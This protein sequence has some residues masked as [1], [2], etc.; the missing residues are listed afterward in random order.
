MKQF[1]EKLLSLGLVVT[2]KDGDLSLKRAKLDNGRSPYDLKKDTEGIVPYLKKHKPELVAYLKKSKN[3]SSSKKASVY[4]LT[5]LQEGMLFHALLEE[6]STAYVVQ[7]AVEFPSGIDTDHFK[8]SWSYVIRNHSILRTAFFH[9][10]LSIPVQRVFPEILPPIQQ[11]DFSELSN[12]EIRIKIDNFLQEDKQTPFV[13]EKAPLFRITLIKTGDESYT[14]VFTNHHIVM[15]GWS[16]SVLIEEFL[17]A[18]EAYSEG[19][20]PLFKEEDKFEDYIRYLAKQDPD[21]EENFWKNYIKGLE[22]PTLLPFIDGITSRNTDPGDLGELI[23]EIDEDQTEKIKSFAQKNR[24]TPNTLIQGTWALLLQHYSGNSNVVYGVTVSGRPTDLENSEKRVGMYINTLPLHA[25]IR[26]GEIITEW[27]KSIQD[28]QIASREHQYT[29]L[30]SIQSMTGIKGELFDTIMAFENYPVA[31]M[32]KQRTMKLEVS[33]VKNQE[34]TNYPLAISIGLHDKM[35]LKFGFNKNLLAAKTVEN[36]RDHFKN[37]LCQLISGKELQIRDIEVIT[38]VEREMFEGWN[39]TFTDYSGK[40]TLLSLFSEKVNEYPTKTALVDQGKEY[41]FEDLDKMSTDLAGYLHKSAQ[42]TSESIVAVELDRGQWFVI[43]ILA[44]LKCNAAY[45]PIDPQYPKERIDFMKKDSQCKFVINKNLISLFSESDHDYHSAP[46]EN[47]APEALAYIIYTSGSTGKPKGVM[48]EHRNIVNTILS[49][50]ENTN[51]SQSDRCLQFS[52]QSFDASVWEI[53]ISLLSGATL[54]IIPDDKKKDTKLFSDFLNDHAITWATLPPAFVRLLQMEDIRPLKTLITAG[55]EAPEDKVRTLGAHTNYVNAYGPTETSICATTFSGDL[56]KKPIPIG[57]PIANTRV[58]IVDRFLR[59]TPVGIP[60][61]LCISGRGVARGYLNRE[62]LTKERFVTNPYEENSIM[63]RTGDLVKRLPDGNIVFIGRVDNQVKIRGYRIEPGEIEQRLLAQHS[64]ENACVIAYDDGAND[65]QLVAYVVIKENQAF[66]KEALQGS[67]NEQLPDYM[68][69]KLWIELDELPIN[70]SGKIDRKAL[71]NPNYEAAKVA[72]VAP[73]TETEKI[74]AS[75]WEELLKVKDIGRYDN[76]FEL[77]GHSLL[78]TRLVSAIRKQLEIELPIK[79][80]F[81]YPTVSLMAAQLVG[82]SNRMTLPVVKPVDNHKGK[83]PLSFSQ[84]RLWFLDN[85]NGSV[86]YHLPFVLKIEGTPDTDL[87]AKSLATIIDRHEILR[88]VYGEQDGIGY[89]EVISSSDWSLTREEVATEAA[90]ESSLE[91]F[92]NHPFDLGEDYMFRACLYRVAGVSGRYVL[93]GVFHHIASDGWSN[94]ILVSEFTELYRSLADGESA[95]LPALPIQYGDYALWQRSY[96]EGEVLEQQLQ[97]WEDQ[98]G[99]TSVLSLPTDYPR[100]SVQSTRGA[101]LRFSL[102][103]SL[104][105]SLEALS[106][107]EGTTLFMTLLAGFKVLLYRYT[108]QDDICVGTP[109]ANRTQK[110]LEGLIGFFV[111]TLALRSDLGGNPSFKELLHQVKQTTLDSYDHQLA[112]FE[113]VVDRVVTSRDMSVTPVFQIMFGWQNTPETPKLEV[114][115]IQLTPMDAGAVS[116]KFDMTITAAQVKK[117]IIIDWEY[118]TDLYS[119]QTVTRMKDHFEQLLEAFVANAEQPIGDVSLVSEKARQQLLKDFNATGVAYPSSAGLMEL[120]SAQVSASGTKT[121]LVYGT[122]EMSYEALDISSGRVASY[123][124]AKGITPGSRVG[125]LSPRSMEMIISMLGILKAGGVYVPLDPSLPQDRLSFIASDA[126]LELIIGTDSDLTG[127]YAFEE[128]PVFDYK[129]TL[130]YEPLGHAVLVSPDAGAYVMYTSGTTGKP[131]GILITH[132][133]I[134][135]L[136]FGSAALQVYPEDRV[137]QWSNYAFDGSTYEIYGSLLHGASLYLIDSDTASDV[138]ALGNVFKTHRLTISFLTPALFNAFVETGLDSLSSVRKL[139]MGGEKA[140]VAHV[141]KALEILGP[142]SLMNGYGPTETTTFAITYT[143][144]DS[145]SIANGVPIGKPLA[146]TSVYIVDTQDQL[147]PVGVIGE[148]CIGGTG[149][150]QGYLNRAELNSEKFVKDPFSADP[151]ARMYRTGDLARWLPDGNIAFVGRADSQVKIRGYRIELGEIETLLLQQASVQ[152]CCVTAWEDAQG[153]KRL[154]GYVVSEQEID[155]SALQDSLGTHLPDYMVPRLWVGLDALPLTRNGKIDYGALPAPETDSL[156][157]ELYVAPESEAEQALATI[158]QELLGVAKVGVH[159]NFFDLGGDSIITIQ[160]VSRLKRYGYHLKPKDIFENQTI[161]KLSAVVSNNTTGIQGEQGLLTGESSLLPIQQW[162]FE[163]LHNGG[164]FNQSVLLSIDKSVDKSSLSAVVSKVYE[165]HDALRFRYRKEGEDWFQYYSDQIGCLDQVVIKEETTEAVSEMITDYCQQYQNSLSIGSG[166]VFRVLHITTP[167]TMDQDRLFMVAHHLVI[168]GVSWRI[169]LDDLTSHLKEGTTAE[170]VIAKGTSYREWSESLGLYAQSRRAISQL[171]YWQEVASSYA[172]LPVDHL[173]EGST[174]RLQTESYSVRLDKEHTGLLLQ[175]V[176]QV[177]GTEIE[178]LLLGCLV[179]TLT[180]W[181]NQQGVTIGLEGHGREEIGGKV[182][183]ST[184]VGWFTNLYPVHLELSDREDLGYVIKTVKEQLRR[185]PDSGMGY[186]ALRYLHPSDEV[187]SSL[188]NTRWD[189]VFNYLGQFD[190]VLEDKNVL[191]GAQEAYGD[192]VS[193]NSPFLNRFEVTASIGGG[194]LGVSFNYAKNQYDKETVESLAE[195]YLWNLRALILHCTQKEEPEKTPSDFGLHQETTVTEFESFQN[196]LLSKYGKRPESIYKLSPLQEG[197]LFHGLYDQNAG[198]YLVQLSL[199]FPSGVALSILRQSWNRIAANHSILRSAFFH[200]ELGAPVQCVFENVEVPIKEVDFS[201]LTPET[202]E[203]SWN[204]LLSKDQRTDFDF[205]QAPLFRITFVKMPDEQARMIFT[206]HHLLI[207]GWSLGVLIEEFLRTYALIFKGQQMPSI[208]HDNFK[209]YIDFIYAKNSFEELQFWENYLESFEE[210]SLLP[211]INNKTSR[212]RI[213][214]EGVDYKF[215]LD[216]DTTERIK[217]FAQKNRLTV[218]TIIQGSWAFLLRSYTGLNGVTFGVTVSGRPAELENS[219]RRV[220]MYI[221]TLPLYVNFEDESSILQWLKKLQSG[222]TAAREHQYSSLSVIQKTVGIKGDFFDTMIAFENFPVADAISENEDGLNVKPISTKEKTNYPLSI[223]VTSGEEIAMKFT[224]NEAILDEETL[225]LITS[226]FEL[227]VNQIVDITVTKLDELNLVSPEAR[228]QLLKDFNATGVA[229]P[230]S[231]GLMELFSAQVSASG[232]KTALVYGTAEMSYEALD[233]S[234]GR[235]ASYLLAKGITPGSRVGILSPRSMEMI[236]SMLG[237]LKAGGVY[238]PLDPSLPQDRLSF[239]ASDA[240]LELIIGTD[241]DLTGAYAFEE[242]PVFDYK[243]TLSYEPLGHAVTVSPDAGAYV[244]YTSGTTG[245]P[246]GALITHRNVI[247]LVFGSAPLQV[248]PEDRVLQWSNYAFDGSTYEIYGSLLHGASLYLIDSDTASDVIAL[249]N[250]FKTHRLT[251]SF[252]TPALFN[253]FVETGLESLSSVRKLIMGGEKASVAHVSKALEILGPGRL[254]N[255]YGPTETT[256]FAIT[257]TIDDSDSIASGVPIGKPLA[258]T[259]VYIVDTQD[260]LVPVGVIGELCIGGTGV[261][262]GYLNRAEL[263]SEKFVKD[264][265]RADPDA[266]MYRTGDLARWLP[267]GN[268]AF[269]GRADSQVKIRGYRI[270]LGE[271][272]TLLLQQASV[273]RCCVTAWEDAQGTKRLVGYVVSEQEIDKAALQDSLGTH[274]PDYMVPRLWV[275]LDALPLTRNGKIDYG[276]LPAPE[277]DGLSGEAYVAPESEAEQALATIWQ[278]LLGVAKVGVHDNFFDLGGHSLLAT[279]L[280]SAIR[281]QFE[282]EV[283]IKDIFI[284]PTVAQQAEMLEKAAQKISLPPI[285]TFDNTEKV[286]LSFSQERIWFL[287]QLQGSIEYHIPMIFELKGKVNAVVMENALRNIIHRHQI[288]RTVLISEE[289]TLY[290]KVL[291][292]SRWY[293]EKAILE[294]EE[295]VEETLMS[296]AYEPFDLSKDFMLRACLY[297]KAKNEY[298]LAVVFHH[299]ASDGWSNGI[300]IREFTEFYRSLISRKKPNLQELEIQYADF[301]QWQR[302]YLEGEVL[303]RMLTYWE[304]K[305]KNTTSL[306]LPTDFPRPAIQSTEGTNLYFKLDKKLSQDLVSLSQEEGVTLFMTLLAAF[307]VLLFKYTAQQDICVGSPIANRTQRELEGLIG[308]FVN[309]LALRS[310]IDSG[311]T[312][313][314]FLKRVKDTTL[315]AYDHQLVPFEKIVEKVVRTRDL[316][317]TPLFQTMFILQNNQRS[318]AVEFDGF[319]MELYEQHAQTAKYDL[320]FNTSETQDGIALEIEYSTALFKEET[321]RTMKVHFENLLS[322]IVKDRTQKISRLTLL[323]QEAERAILQKLYAEKQ[324]EIPEKTVLQRFEEQVEKNPEAI[325]LEYESE[326]FTYRQINNYAN[327]LAITLLEKHDTPYN[328]VGI[329]M[330]RSPEMIVAILAAFKAGIAYVPIDPEY[331]HERIKYIIEDAGLKSVF[332]NSSV[333]YVFENILID[334]IEEVV[335]GEMENE[336]FELPPSVKNPQ[337]QQAYV[338]Y[339]SGSTGKPKGVLVGQDT[340][341]VK[342]EEET[343]LLQIDSNL[344]GCL[345]TNFVFDVSLLDIF[346]PLTNGGKIIIPIQEEVQEVHQLKARLISG[347]VNLLQGT[348]SFFSNLLSVIEPG[349]ADS[350]SLRCCCV[351]G[352][353]LQESLVKEFQYK[354]PAVQINNHY[355]P[356]EITIDAVVLQNITSFT[357]NNIGFPLPG[358]VAYILDEA[359]QLVPKGIIGELCI[360]GNSLAKGYLNREELTDKRFIPD[361]FRNDQKSRIYRTGDL[362]R[363]LPDGSIEFIGRKDDQVKIRGYRIE[364]GEIEKN[365]TDLNQVSE[366]CVKVLTDNAGSQQLVGYVAMPESSYDKE[367][368]VSS[369]KLVLPDYMIPKIW[370]RLDKMPITINGK[371]DRKQLPEPDAQSISSVL[372]EPPVTAL[373]IKLANIWGSLLKQEKIGIHDNFFELGGHSLL[374]T[375]LV[376]AIRSQLNVEITIKDIFLKPTISGLCEQIVGLKSGRSL[377]AIKPTELKEKFPLSFSQERLW[378]IHE[379]Q[380]SVHY[381]MPLVLRIKGTVK[382]EILEGSFLEILRRHEVL[383]TRILNSEGIGYQK[384]VSAEDWKLETGTYQD[385]KLLH[386]SIYDFVKKPFNLSTDFMLRAALL[387]KGAEEHAMIVVTHHIAS[388][389]WSES[390]LMHEFTTIYKSFLEDHKLQL[391][392]VNLQYKDYAV[393]ERIHLEGATLH[394]LIKYWQNQLNGVSPLELPLDFERPQVQN[395]EGEILE[396]TIDKPLTS[397]IKTLATSN[398]STMFMTLLTAYKVFLHRYS[399]QEDIC[400]GTPVS[401]RTQAELEGVIGFFANTLALRSQITGSSTFH[402]LLEIIKNN[403]TE[404]FDHQMAPFEK[405]VDSIINE[406]DMSR[407][408]LFQTMFVFQNTPNAETVSFSGFNAEKMMFETKTSNFDLTFTITESEGKLIGAVQYATALFKRNTI[409]KMQLHFV[410]LLQSIVDQPDIPVAS[411]S[412]IEKEDRERLLI[413]YNKTR[414]DLETNSSLIDHFKKQ[415]TLQS[416]KTAL[417]DNNTSYSYKEIDELSGK[418]ANY[419]LQ[420]NTISSEDIIG[421]ELARSAGYIVSILAILKTGAAY[422]SIDPEY[423]EERI[424]YM[425][426]DSNCRFSIDD[427]LWEDFLQNQTEFDTNVS[428]GEICSDQLA[429][430]IYTS[431][432]TGKPKGVMIEHKGILNTILSQIKNTGVSNQDRCLQFANPSFDASVWEIWISLLAGATLYIVPEACKKDVDL[433]VSYMSTAEITWATL[434]PAFVRLLPIEGLVT[435]KTLITAGEKAPAEQ[436]SK[437][438]KLG[439]YINAYGPT[440]TSICASTFNGNVKR[441]NVPIGKPIANTFIYILNEQLEPVPEGVI[442][443]ICVSGDGLSRGY[444]NREELTAEKFVENPFLKQTRLYKTGDLARWNSEGVLEFIGRKDDQIKINGY[445]VE[446]GEIESA[447]TALSEVR[448]ACVVLKE[449]VHGNKQLIAYIVHDHSDEYLALVKNQLKDIL[450]SYMIPELWIQIDK[451]PMTRNGKVDKTAL[452]DPEYSETETESYVAPQNEVEERLSEIWAEIL[453]FRVGTNTNFFEAGGNSISAMKL[454]AKI[455]H[456]FDTKLNVMRLFG[457]PTISGVAEQ[458]VGEGVAETKNQLII[459]FRTSG[460]KTPVFCVHPVQGTA[461]SFYALANALPNDQPFYGIQSSGLDGIG[462][463][464][465]S[466]KEMAGAYVSAIQEIQP[467]GPY[468]FA[469]YSLGGKIAFEMAVM[470]QERGEE[471]EDLWL[472]DADAFSSNENS[473]DLDLLLSMIEQALADRF[474]I[475]VKLQR[476]SSSDLVNQIMDQ[477]NGKGVPL[478]HNMLKGMLRVFLNNVQLDTVISDKV[479]QNTSVRLFRTSATPGE[480]QNEDL[481]W[482]S[483]V[484]SK[485]HITSFNCDHEAILKNPVVQEIAHLLNTDEVAFSAKEGSQLL[486]SF[487]K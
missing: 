399:H 412:L 84:E 141:S 253:A 140:S 113:K 418:L 433:F 429:Y 371:I 411:L 478:D 172:P 191:S 170:K 99:D 369:L 86:A 225:Q 327:Q 202:L 142:G 361:P 420:K 96:L 376:S 108:G 67:L 234:S 312:F 325:A 179:L 115:G 360:G 41:S 176:H 16:T 323:D 93:A 184:T 463:L 481:G 151:D 469:G 428:V 174:L 46:F 105:A 68:V 479:L 393:W 215:R 214:V 238:V 431:G 112:P 26:G 111:N 446:L 391:P 278:E 329:C 389:G 153:T 71:P 63:Y 121:A 483:Y 452:P 417:V 370:I 363:W 219:E 380:G 60:G 442:G 326:L 81:K 450:P 247:S 383:R 341:S 310:E 405:V 73:E 403:T 248:Y 168:D 232:T 324:F 97:Y 353:S 42:L 53:W 70:S 379:L 146:N 45:L 182:D 461:T 349:E 192:E 251:V 98:L 92:I 235:V 210:P 382:K 332:V 424:A 387:S 82:E 1:I 306:L 282:T 62:E 474:N 482:Q 237:I 55:E 206:S 287:D 61:E 54:F 266:R 246:K 281:K 187:R 33:N 331:P 249:G 311:E 190:N 342:I 304:S 10:E 137:L 292:V 51:V 457:S 291:P 270:E 145:D 464:H 40:E 211:F 241:S 20:N 319:K 290:Q 273:Q 56:A 162:Y 199:E 298:I 166:P 384:I 109:I 37:V 69:P 426:S 352:E 443:E 154:V 409:K 207:D 177:Y 78:A 430:I 285:T 195:S 255:G 64:V 21:T 135:S 13:F 90:L 49:Q 66:D 236:I 395:I 180:D 359:Q 181:S 223:S 271:I 397:Q 65:K 486:K 448:D 459:P 197:M 355:G 347:N 18:Y 80:V 432:S 307:K 296:Y 381:H 175:E 79:N 274:L 421:I 128:I 250:V 50:I 178:D 240:G 231:V 83:I 422:L 224:Y 157:G 458:I 203:E 392:P 314:L 218:N 131:K 200:N 295:A 5:P 4:K 277:T 185:I 122:A 259:S 286:P 339:T 364:L 390:I 132:K 150:S 186:G 133:N 435:L 160:V 348:P 264:P 103:E 74:L 265:F 252:L 11:L 471:V 110:E 465:L 198:S 91:S 48:V 75:I 254:M 220:G 470:L 309:T 155:K 313:A 300:L 14:M 357:K 173:V 318:E 95:N 322:S 212:N 400:V 216:K 243:E 25:E 119:E 24:L 183:L 102:S 438:S 104:S 163:T 156:S 402:Q 299:I 441:E 88:T 267:D 346:L 147:V 453:G 305:L 19:G 316:S 414:L 165:Q 193:I 284:H 275:G 368:L 362:A 161:A 413:A 127:A 385:E 213:S 221:N 340:L 188:A 100:P 427:N 196:K 276:A 123:L 27:L 15:D 449:I 303:Q 485:I 158:W 194:T 136:V 444:L 94:G 134:S 423:P 372:F 242:I 386:D 407:S 456:V 230:S 330:E 209:D 226:H 425:K 460:S 480:K 85:L 484:S 3:N 7:L 228:Q 35:I 34:K 43:A 294:Q 279:R 260:Q 377:P 462:S 6:E 101:S 164:A 334:S 301:A 118:C 204:D 245:K 169:L 374:A 466:M 477:I 451:I 217:S 487:E 293:M 338:I 315:D 280:V 2:E 419:L 262:Q 57:V 227:L 31:E 401:N 8:R 415:V 476:N 72:Y 320:T 404:A 354:L 239:I 473:V 130:S 406:R 76:F 297:E 107:R 475:Y 337:E 89:Q 17:S 455:N 222:H 244:M 77:G 366:G 317:T 44:I 467:K 38:P 336:T 308:F 439:T 472:L 333:K 373:E 22:E 261:S 365:I 139:I 87:I 167:E 436:A 356:T 416:Q 9:K 272:E 149:V 171:G 283:L 208:K 201:E 378:F 454:V 189:V 106:K 335:L 126:G 159:D 269:V 437:F 28:G 152:R 345:V 375:R 148:L 116:S 144:D 408:P 125:I 328:R 344:I 396:F 321:I 36:I 302:T 205:Q 114:E 143:I 59:Q 29:G 263:N 32:L 288:L 52:S 350:F 440:E 388:D 124:L 117:N 233:I 256:T 289:N 351:G 12:D 447:L 268:I 120:F 229:Y 129:E 258:N 367:Q 30:A 410:Q 58:Y 468:R 23:L 445:R 47:I 434:P 398:R 257:Y 138:I 394:S 39:Q 358:T 343:S